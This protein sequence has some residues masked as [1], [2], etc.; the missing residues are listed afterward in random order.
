[1]INSGPTP[2]SAAILRR[3]LHDQK[4]DGSWLLNPPARDRHATFDAVFV[5]RQLGGDRPACRRALAR[6]AGWALRCRNGDGGFG[7]FPGSVSDTDAVYFQV[8][9]LVMAGVLKSAQLAQADAR[10]LG[11]GHVF[12]LP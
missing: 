6:A 11:W 7:H 5:V 1:M 9:T 12:P 3:A 2:K 4:P 10:L 8:G